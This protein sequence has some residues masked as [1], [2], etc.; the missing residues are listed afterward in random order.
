VL[1]AHPSFLLR[2]AP[3]LC[4]LDFFLCNCTTT[5]TFPLKN[6]THP[7][8]AFDLLLKLQYTCSKILRSGCV[9][10]T[11]GNIIFQRSEERSSRPGKML[12]S[13]TEFNKVFWNIEPCIVHHTVH[14]VRIAQKM[15]CQC[16]RWNRLSS[17]LTSSMAQ[18]PH[19][20][21]VK[22]AAKPMQTFEFERYSK[23][24]GLSFSLSS[25]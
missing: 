2:C 15:C 22:I 16:K 18:W 21:P 5:N 10:R 24:N 23:K 8:H 7:S 11:S 14:I 6:Y 3:V 9:L 1:R 19:L 4:T 13:H 17:A 20:R 12:P 25:F